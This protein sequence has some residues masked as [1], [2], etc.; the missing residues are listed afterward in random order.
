M[1]QPTWESIFKF[2]KVLIV[3]LL[4]DSEIPFLEMKLKHM[5]TQNLYMNIHGSITYNSQKIETNENV[6]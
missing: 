3:E 1:V 4:Y 6:N 5:Y 2:L